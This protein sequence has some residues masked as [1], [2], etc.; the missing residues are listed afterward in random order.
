MDCAHQKALNLNVS[1]WNDG[2]LEYRRSAGKGLEQWVSKP[3]MVGFS[4]LVIATQIKIDPM[5]EKT[6][7]PTL[8]YSIIPIDNLT[9]MPIFSDPDLITKFSS[10]E[11]SVNPPPGF[12]F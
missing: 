9:A 4:F 8:H 7:N 5:G 11:K 1:D 6:N 12:S 3:M 2:I 10:L